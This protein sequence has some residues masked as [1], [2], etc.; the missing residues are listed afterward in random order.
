MNQSS[1]ISPFLSHLT[2]KPLGFMYTFIQSAQSPLYFYYASV[3]YQ[4]ILPGLCNILLSGIP[5]SRLVLMSSSLTQKLE[6]TFKNVRSNHSLLPISLKIK[7]HY[8]SPKVI[9]YRIPDLCPPQKQLISWQKLSESTFTE[10]WNLV[11]NTTKR[12]ELKKSC[13]NVVRESS[14]IFY[15]RLVFRVILE[16]WQ[17]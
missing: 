2:F 11:I 3:N 14:V 16:L 8:S 4:H 5:V 10:L 15:N 1:L 12:N 6:Q 13:C 7:G 17:N 9:T